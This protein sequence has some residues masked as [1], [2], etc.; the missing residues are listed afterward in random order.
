MDAQEWL[1]RSL[2]PGSSFSALVATQLDRVVSWEYLGDGSAAD[3]DESGRG[4]TAT[5]RRSQLTTY[6]AERREENPHRVMLVENMLM[7]QGDPNIP[8]RTMFFGEHAVLREPITSD[9]AL[10]QRLLGTAESGWVM[11]AFICASAMDHIQADV[12]DVR[13]RQLAESV[14]HILVSVFDAEGY[15]AY[16]LAEPEGQHV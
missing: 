12:D 5:S 11:N 14:E 4:A 9:P 3:F 2:R 8:S 13:A 7:R 16:R 6:L 1:E 15:L 10:M